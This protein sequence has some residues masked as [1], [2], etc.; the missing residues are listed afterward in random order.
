MPAMEIK[1]LRAI[2]TEIFKI[3]I[4]LH[5]ELFQLLTPNHK[6]TKEPA[7]VDTKTYG[8]KV[9]HHYAQRFGIYFQNIYKSKHRL[10]YSKTI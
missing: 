3:L 10:Q 4:N 9:L 2:A 1:R 5:E 8:K 7:D 6:K